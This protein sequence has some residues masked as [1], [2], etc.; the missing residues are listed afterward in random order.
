MLLAAA[1]AFGLLLWPVRKAG[2]TAPQTA[3]TSSQPLTSSEPQTNRTGLKREF[4]PAEVASAVAES[5]A[6]VAK[7]EKERDAAWQFYNGDHDLPV[8]L[9]GRVV[10]Q[11]TKPLPDVAVNV[12]IIDEYATRSGGMTGRTE[13]VQIQTGADGRFEVSGFRGNRV[14]VE[15]LTKDGYEPELQQHYGFVPPRGTTFDSPAVLRLWSTNFHEPLIEGEKSFVV[16]PDGRHYAIDLVKGTIDE[17]EQGDL[18]LWIK[19]P[20]IVKRPKRYEWASEVGVPAGGLLENE[21][22]AM[23]VAPELG[24]T[25]AF[26]HREEAGVNGWGDGFERKL[27]YLKLRKAQM[28]GRMSLDLY[29]Y[30][31][32]KRPALI[33][34]S[35]AINPSGS[36]LLR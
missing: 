6:V 31:D 29:A 19:R 36:R 14:A 15:G 28:Y 26:A 5:N 34:I 9:Y 1:L 27:F 8:A 13:R 24:Y 11:D 4:D 17:S 35:Y 21:N 22:R 33:R 10:D 18:V 12:A 32:E 23:F 20:E 30:Y 25:N 2:T 3:E 7:Y 16:I